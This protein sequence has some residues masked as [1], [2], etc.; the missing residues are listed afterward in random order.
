MALR[1]CI[2]IDSL[3]LCILLNDNPSWKGMPVAVTREEKPRSPI[4][5]LNREAREHGLAVGMRYAQ[6]LALVPGLRARAVAQ[7]RVGEA[8]SLV[9]KELSAFTPDVEPCSFDDNAFWASV[10][11]LR[12]LFPSESIWADKVRSALSGKGFP[13]SVVIGFTRFGTYAIARSQPRRFVFS[14]RQEERTTME[15][16]SID[17]LPLPGRARNTLRKLGVHTVRQ[18]IALP[19]AETEQHLGTEAALLRSLVLS[20]DP[21]PV[22]SCGVKEDL[23]S[24]RHLDAPVG[25]LPQLMEQI[26]QLLAVERARAEAAASVI[27]SLTLTLR[28]EDGNVTTDIIRPSA[29]TLHTPLLSRLIH[30]R[31]C[32]R[33]LSSGVEDLQVRTTRTQP[34]RE[35]QWLFASR[36]RDLA[37]GSRAFA[38]LRARFGNECVVCARLCDSHLPERS[39]T[40]VS[41]ER[42]VLPSVRQDSQPKDSTVLVRRILVEPRLDSLLR[43]GGGPGEAPSGAPGGAPNGGPGPAPSGAPNGVPDV[44]PSGAPGD[45]PI[46]FLLSG[47]WWEDN[48]DAGSFVREYSFQKTRAGIPWLFRDV[49]TG[50][51]FIQGLVD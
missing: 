37:A 22:S 17:I 11:G 40:W 15:K 27:S 46:P 2:N 5:A 31:L 13:A 30:L 12:S 35:Q 29:P 38:S 25:D 34:S 47:A 42:P 16:S 21:L 36:G 49:R 26:D 39:F 19:Q 33:Q 14:S 10:D 9:M 41:M 50:A 8:Q 23:G 7:V 4:L 20:D 3:P 43:E 28:S 1:G 48:E 51:R 45:A 32:S 18:F 24:T 44:A 6:A